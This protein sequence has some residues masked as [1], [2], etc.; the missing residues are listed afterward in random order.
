MFQSP[1]RGVI[2]AVEPARLARGVES[3]HPMVK[4]GFTQATTMR[5]RLLAAAV[6]TALIAAARMAQAGQITYTIQ[7]YP[8][9]QQGASLSGEI[10]TDGVTGSLATTDI[11]SWSWTIT[12]SGGTPFTLLRLIL[13]AQVFLFPGSV[14]VV[15]QSAITMRRAP[16]YPW[17][18][19]ALET[20]SAGGSVLPALGYDRPGSQ[21]G[22]SDYFAMKNGAD[23]WFTDNPAM[24]GNDPWVIAVAASSVPEP[25]GVVL[26]GRASRD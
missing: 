9:D 7:N 23:V 11:V 22:T 16:Q 12:P 17:Q 4:S 6:A 21:G 25:S 14:L 26:L 5:H 2:P 10:T 1:R 19:L 13:E 15:S 24:G 18:Q 3:I 20:V 8:A